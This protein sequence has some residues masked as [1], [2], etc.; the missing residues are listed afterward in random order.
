MTPRSAWCVVVL[1][2]C[3]SST[4]S[5]G[6]ADARIVDAPLVLPADAP[7]ADAPTIA[8]D[9][10]AGG[11][12]A[13]LTAIA[14]APSDASVVLDGAAAPPI[15][16][17]A[18]GRLADDRTVTLDPAALDWS[19]S[20][21][22]DTPPG[23]ISAGG[24]F[25][26]F[27]GAGGVVTVEATDGC[28]TGAT[29][30]TF[31]VQATEGSPPAG[32]DG[33]TV[34]TGAGAPVIVYPSDGTRLPRNVYRTLFQWQSG[35][36]GPF[37]LVFTGPGG[38]YTVYTDG[39]HPLCAG[40]TPP[41]ACW[42]TDEADWGFIAGSNAGQTATL[43]V[44]RLDSS[45]AA[46][47]ARRSAPIELGFSRRD[48]PGAIFYWSTTS[49]GIRRGSL[50][51]A[52]PEDYMTGD[53]KTRYADGD[54]VKCVACHVVSRDGKYLAAPTES[55]DHRGLW[56]LEVTRE[57]PPAPLVQEIAGTGGHG[58][59]TFSPDNQFL[60]AAWNGKLWQLE[61]ETGVK[62]AD[63]ALGSL[64]GT[65]PDWSPDNTQLVFAT[66]AKDGPD[67]AGLA[68]VSYGGGTS[69][70]SPQVL[71]AAAGGKTNLFPQFS[72]DGKWIAFS[73]GDRGGHDDPTM[74]LMVVRAMP[75]SE[76]V[77][78]TRA[79]CTVSTASNDCRTENYEPTWAPPGD[80]EWIAFNSQ[81]RYGVVLAPGTTQLWIAAIDPARI[82]SGDPSYP[83]FRVPFQG[84]DEHNHRAFWTQDIRET[85]PLP[86]A[87]VPDAPTG[88]GADARACIADNQTCDPTADSCCS[89][90]FVCDSNDD[91]ETYQ[92]L[93]MGIE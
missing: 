1:A 87:G 90:L 93:R 35:G 75:G 50:A 78:L 24:L 54:Q 18:T 30:V 84:L 17:M 4:I 41:A 43:T 45:G 86:D 22:D 83:A 73:R 68:L 80:L 33:A 82:G 19:V 2:G 27:A 59:A 40:K 89:P 85:Q 79:N 3:G 46:P 10:A 14:L 29:T 13:G 56:V 39:A 37:R 69:W 70:G 36:A 42:E 60:V 67:N 11:C 21:A 25:T 92:C 51:A 53:P 12:I 66:G 63:L 55:D 31:T 57:P 88:P 61:R 9:G 65:H 15:A 16:F 52:V 7:L 74:Q 48:V 47:V 32:W 44:D 8:A 6:G 72:F 34:M 26:P 81:R 62:V 49:K 20:R 71:V 64:L 5:G 76:P 77:E 91:G 28:V 23:T 58:F 38:G